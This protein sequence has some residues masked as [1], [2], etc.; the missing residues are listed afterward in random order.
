MLTNHHSKVSKL[1]PVRTAVCA[2]CVSVLCNECMCGCVCVGVCVGVCGCVCVC[3]CMGVCVS[4]NTSTRPLS[5]CSPALLIWI[6]SRVETNLFGVLF[7][8]K[9]FYFRGRTNKKSYCENLNLTTISRKCFHNNLFF[10]G[11]KN[12]CTKR[13]SEHLKF[14]EVFAKMIS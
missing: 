7:S 1:V 4:V 2:D 10:R 5:C 6:L 11:R 14:D 9:C 13:F 8:R 12:I 3:V